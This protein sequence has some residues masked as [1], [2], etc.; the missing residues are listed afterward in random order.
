MSVTNSLFLW[1]GGQDGAEV[2]VTNSLFLWVGGQDGA[3]V[4]VT[5]SLCLWVGGQDVRRCQSQ[6]RC[7]SG[8][9]VR[10]VRRC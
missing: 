2:L 1:V 7:S 3:E 5:N 10:T 8:W 4:L 9:E 6:T